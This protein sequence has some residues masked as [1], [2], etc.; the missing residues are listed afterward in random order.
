TGGPPLAHSE[1]YFLAIMQQMTQ[2]MTNLQPSSSSEAS[3]P[4]T[5]MIPSMKALAP[6]TQ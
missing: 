6:I 4:P 1:P 5:F 3:G 2:I